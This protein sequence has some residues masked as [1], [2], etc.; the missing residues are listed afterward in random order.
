ML[1]VNNMTDEV[2]FGGGWIFLKEITC[3][4][5]IHNGLRK[6]YCYMKPHALCVR[7]TNMT[8]MIYDDI[9]YVIKTYELSS[10]RITQCTTN[11]ISKLLSVVADIPQLCQLNIDDC[12]DID[13]RAAVYIANALSGG[14]RLTS[15]RLNY[16]GI[17]VD[18]FRHIM[19]SVTVGTVLRELYMDCVGMYGSNAADILIRAIPHIKSLRVLSVN[20]RWGG[21]CDEICNA[22]EKNY[23]ITHFHICGFNNHEPAMV[24]IYNRNCHIRFAHRELLDIAFAFAPMIMKYG[25]FDAYCMMWI[26]DYVNDANI[27]VSEFKKIRIIKSVFEFYRRKMHDKQLRAISLCS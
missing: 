3:S 10:L 14:I 1:L 17:S 25:C 9:S 5:D 12:R 20:V 4:A 26:F 23:T 21:G 22:L 7:M 24:A 11:D 8:D 13:N 19:E 27:R 15:L 18:G 16:N 2:T 6:I